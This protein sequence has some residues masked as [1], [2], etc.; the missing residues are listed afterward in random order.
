M[1]LYLHLSIH[2]FLSLL[3]GFVAW[4]MWKCPAVSFLSGITGGFLIDLDHFIDYFLAFGTHFRF[5]YFIV[6]Y[7]F[8]KSDKLYIFFHAW[9][10]GILLVGLVFVVKNRILKSIFLG[11]A[12]GLFFHLATDVVVDEV[13]P[14]TY[15]I[16][17]RIQNDFDIEKLV[18]DHWEEHKQMKKEVNFE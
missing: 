8:L 5:D 11:V 13:P 17:Q 12:L 2:L 3:A 15:S 10:Y 14:A 9:E 18:P 6:G 7:Q 16:T 1:N 4:R